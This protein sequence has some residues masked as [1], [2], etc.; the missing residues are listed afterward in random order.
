MY[1]YCTV[2]HIRIPQMYVQSPPLFYTPNI[3]IYTGKE[4]TVH[5]IWDIVHDQF[6]AEI[7]SKKAEAQEADLVRFK[8]RSYYQ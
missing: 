6:D 2:Y 4:V 7:T 1:N 3:F 8:T 5:K